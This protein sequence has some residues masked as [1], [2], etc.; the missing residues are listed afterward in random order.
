M[1]L[2][3]YVVALICLPLAL[4]CTFTVAPSGAQMYPQPPFMAPYTPGFNL[5]VFYANA[6]VKYRNLQTVR[7]KIEPHS[8]FQTHSLGVPTFGPNTDG[9]LLYPYDAV[10]GYPTG[11]PADSPTISGIWSYD[12][13]YVDPRNPGINATDG[14]FFPPLRALGYYNVSQNNAG[15]FLVVIPSLQTD[16]VGGIYAETTSVTLSRRLDGTVD[17]A[18]EPGPET[19]SRIFEGL[20]GEEYDIRFTDKIWTPY[21]EFGYRA[22]SYFDCIFGISGFNQSNTLQRT[23]G[24]QARMY[25]RTFRDTFHYE[26]SNSAST[27]LEPFDSAIDATGA[28]PDP[29]QFYAI[30]PAGQSGG[31]NL[32]TRRFT[33]E[34]DPFIPPI[35]A[36]ETIYNRIDF[37]AIEIKAGG[38]S[39]FPLYGL[40]EIGT[41]LGL[42]VTPMPV[43]IVTSS[44]VVALEDNV[45]AGVTAGDVL[46]Y[47][48]NKHEDFWFWQNIGAFV[49]LDLRLGTGRFFGQS[50]LEYDVYFADNTYNG[51]PGVTN[52]VNISGLNASLTA[53]ASF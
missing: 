9:T 32:P 1:K 18:F 15:S 40:G 37:T 33:I 28:N 49:G 44:R 8:V 24:V 48:A 3:T 31:V 10:L 12:D 36:Q 7:T 52:S 26:S 2:R 38:R 42:L 20:S 27:W 46:V 39:W 47:T 50:T 11:N 45:D 21:V 25:R 41:S 22:S 17:P 19:A 13:G 30:Y 5:G 16:N 35:A 23:Y 34:L 6:G 14:V 43:T 53:G 4:I 51:F 29:A